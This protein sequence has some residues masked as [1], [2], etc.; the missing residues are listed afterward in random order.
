MASA[1]THADIVADG[2]ELP[3]C[4]EGDE[5]RLRICSSLSSHCVT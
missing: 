3:E 4:L 5:L 1:Q 2:G